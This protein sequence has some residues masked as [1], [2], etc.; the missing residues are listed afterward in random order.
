V[1]IPGV[2]FSDFLL[3]RC[4]ARGEAPAFIDGPTGRVLTF[5]E[6]AE[7]AE[8][9]A[10]GLT[11]RG[12][13]RGHVVA[14]LS[15][16]RPEYAVVLIGAIRA[17]C[18]VT[19]INPLL[20]AGEI[21][22]QLRDSGALLM[23]TVPELA[24]RAAEA[25]AGSQLRDIV[26]FGDAIGATPLA[27][28]LA[29]G[30][31]HI[32]AVGQPPAVADPRT[33]VAVMLYSSGTTGGSKGVLLTHRNLV[34]NVLQC[35][36]ALPSGQ[37]DTVIAGLPFSHVYGLVI[38]VSFNIWRGTPVVCFPRFD[39]GSFLGAVQDRRSRT[40]YIVPPIVH[41]LAKQPLVDQFGLGV[42]R[43]ICGAASLGDDIQHACSERLGCLVGQGWGMTECGLGAA[44][45]LDR[46][47]QV[48]P[49]SSG[50]LVP[51]CEAK[52]VDVATGRELGPGEQ[53]ELWLRGPN[54]MRGYLDRPQET[55]AALV[56]GWLRTG[57]IGYA[58]PDGWIYIVDRAK[59]LIKYKAF[60]I[61]PA[62]LEA[63]LLTHPA[64]LDAVVPS[65]DAEAG[66]VP[67][68]FI[69]TRAEVDLADLESRVAGQVA[70]HKRIRRFEVVSQIP[71]TPS[72]KI[73]RRA[74]IE[75]ER[76]A[77]SPGRHLTPHLP[78]PRHRR[79]SVTAERSPLQN[80]S[81]AK[82]KPNRRI[83]N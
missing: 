70:P 20:T 18:V 11:A 76:A 71:R 58:D 66:D 73:L 24:G 48:R 29:A 37:G 19:T 43:I 8:S 7:S 9:F 13:E 54:V 28:I 55:A 63:L 21:G 12:L 53:G 47:E 46:P 34:A 2:S 38:L 41:A 56:D 59:E 23:V 5:A 25:A 30:R 45:P 72:G 16:N 68:A 77:A 44:N 15:P 26:V 22:Q 6:L 4:R 27:R 17:G 52:F 50:P 42:E 79:G 67:K 69:V 31:G 74:L 82:D 1:S 80:P 49:G 75:Q 39:L 65:P 64:V 61:A 81:L 78:P 36:A 83:Q 14:I 60:A 57:D 3:G 33:D 62:E 51:G 40:L 10:A 35:Q 32:Q